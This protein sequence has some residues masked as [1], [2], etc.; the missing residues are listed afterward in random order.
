MKRLWL[1]P[2]IASF[3]NFPAYSADKNTHATAEGL[4]NGFQDA[5]GGAHPKMRRTHAKGICFSGTFQPSEQAKKNFDLELTNT[6]KPLKVI[7]R[8][9]LAGGDPQASDKSR[10]AR[11]M[12][13]R[14]YLN[15][16]RFHQM[17]MLST[18]VFAAATPDSFLGLLQAQRMDPTTKKRDTQKI[19][20]YIKNNPD[21]QPQA[22]WLKE[23]SPPASFAQSS[24]FGISTFIFKNKNKGSTSVR[25]F[26]APQEG[27]KLLT[28]DEMEKGPDQFLETELK[29][30]LGKKPA[31]WDWTVMKSLKEDNLINPTIPWDVAKHQTVKMGELKIDKVEET[32]VC[33]DFNFDPLV[34]TKGVEASE[35]PILRIRSGAYAISFGRRQIE[36]T[37][38]K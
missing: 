18:P 38:N 27:E 37:Q 21:T 32:A 14:F 12:A 11:G 24:Y 5:F 16:D 3:I 33:D 6:K 23:H 1:T 34:L 29:E 7:G 4:V 28:A 15:D 13:L 30:H 19:A 8:F 20:D 9:S 36:K 2:L 31:V 26:F 17:A 10:S 35:D 22:N 25:W